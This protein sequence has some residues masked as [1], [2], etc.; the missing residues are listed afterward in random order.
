MKDLW[1]FL[2]KGRLTGK[3][4]KNLLLVAAVSGLSAVIL[5]LLEP[6]TD[7]KHHGFIVRTR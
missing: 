6:K 7:F 5:D 2:K 4:G 3:A 1:L